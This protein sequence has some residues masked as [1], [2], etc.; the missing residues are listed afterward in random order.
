MNGHGF[1]PECDADAAGHILACRHKG[2]CYSV[3]GSYCSQAAACEVLDK[4]C[5]AQWVLNVCD[6]R[7]SRCAAAATVKESHVQA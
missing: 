3:D 7:C 1:V 5:A 4:R 2:R 6:G